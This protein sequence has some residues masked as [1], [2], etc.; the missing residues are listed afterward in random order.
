MREERDGTDNMVLC[1]FF[2]RIQWS[3]V[4]SLYA[5]N[6]HLIV[7]S[8]YADNGHLSFLRMQTMVI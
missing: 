4:I 6:G 2:V 8:V 5:D 1:H 7:I 3:F